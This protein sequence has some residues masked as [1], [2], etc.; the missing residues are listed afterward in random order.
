MCG[1]HLRGLDLREKG[2][3][4]LSLLCSDVG[5]VRGWGVQIY[6][7]PGWDGFMDSGSLEGR[8]R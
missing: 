8:Q 1:S 3:A 4:S 2:E 6:L 5:V 7:L